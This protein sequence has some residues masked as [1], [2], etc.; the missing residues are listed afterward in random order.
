MDTQHELPSKLLLE[1][2]VHT[3]K[4]IYA[5]HIKIEYKFLFETIF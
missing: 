3:T 5:M 1:L 4:L 2:I